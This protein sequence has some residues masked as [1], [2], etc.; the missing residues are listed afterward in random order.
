VSIISIRDED[1]SPRARIDV[2]GQM[3]SY[4][5][6]STDRIMQEYR[7]VI[8]MLAGAAGGGIAIGLMEAFSTRAAI[9]LVAIPFATSIVL[10]MGS[11]EVEAAQPR[12]LIG[13][14]I[15]STIVGL[16]VL[17]IAGPEPWAAALAV[18]LA[19]AAMQFTRTFHP[20]AG[21]DPLLV[22]VNNMPWGFLLVPVA[23]GAVLLA[24]FA[25]VWHILIRRYSWPIRWW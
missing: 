5:R 14:H 19:I 11:P 23:A 24:L 21:I 20:P 15:V 8:A 10:V 13:G 7:A 17:N 4:K 3:R 25:F 9:P 2:K 22:V 1:N 12:A 16:V 18:G 6:L